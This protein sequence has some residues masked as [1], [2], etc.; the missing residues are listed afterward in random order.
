MEPGV[1]KLLPSKADAHPSGVLVG[2]GGGKT[3]FQPKE[4]ALLPV[5]DKAQPAPLLRRLRGAG[6]LVLEL[7][8]VPLGFPQGFSRRDDGVL[9]VRDA[10]LLAGSYRA[11]LATQVTRMALDWRAVNSKVLMRS[12][13]HS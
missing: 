5:Q 4:A 6:L 8:Q 9:Q 7:R 10:I 3:S 1:K 11:H 13:C 12:R 2:P